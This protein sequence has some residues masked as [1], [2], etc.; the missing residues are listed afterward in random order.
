MAS[1]G[2]GRARLP[3]ESEGLD[4]WWLQDGC[5]QIIKF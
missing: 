1:P 2:C 4:L 3:A 5:E